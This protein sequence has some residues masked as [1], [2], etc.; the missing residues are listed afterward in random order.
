VGKIAAPLPAKLVMGLLA[1]DHDLLE[2]CRG[3]CARVLGAIDLRSA[4][5]PFEFTT[6]YEE[7]MGKGLLRQWVSYE[8]LCD[9]GELPAVKHRTNQIERLFAVEQK[10]TVNLDPGYLTESRLVLASTKDFAH[11]IYLGKGVYGELTLT[12]HRG[13]FFPLEWT[14]PDYR[15]LAATD[16]FQAVRNRYR[17]QLNA[18]QA[19]SPAGS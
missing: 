2:K 9:P 15:I 1:R 16:F 18:A 10:R 14:Y 19:A 7:E 13:T 4:T 11:R 3:E 6:Y 8:A 17:E 5:I 12:Y